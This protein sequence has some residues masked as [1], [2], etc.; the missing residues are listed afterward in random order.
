MNTT[1]KKICELLSDNDNY[2]ILT[3]RHPDCDTLGSAA[4]L[5]SLLHALG[6]SARAVC[7]DTVP[8]KYRCLMGGYTY[9]DSGEGYD[10]IISVDVAAGSMLGEYEYLKDDVFIKIDH[11]AVRDDFGEYSYVKA[12][13][14]SCAEIILDICEYFEKKGGYALTKEAASY[15][16]CGV[17]SDTGGFIYSNTTPE[18]HIKAARLLSLGIP[19]SKLDEK[20]HITKSPGRIRAE[21]YALSG[22]KYDCGGKLASVCISMKIRAELDIAEEDISDIVDIPRSIEGVNIAFSVKEYPDGTYRVS[23]RSG[24]SDVSAVAAVFGGGGHVRAAGCT[25]R[26]GGIE[27]AREAV[28]AECRKQIEK[29]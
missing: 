6:K 13:S 2:L 15:I 21:G 16:Y 5:M 20:L 8:E 19:A 26:A 9:E 29:E 3:H 4:A 14:A 28:A 10:K 1:I 18:T 12:D 23:L 11:H 27:E 17:S 24:E 25:L 22:I 7:P